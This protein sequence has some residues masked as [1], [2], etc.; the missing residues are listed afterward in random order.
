MTD[1]PNCGSNVLEIDRFCEECGHSL[2][3]DATPA[4][5]C[6]RCGA[7]AS[8]IDEE[9]FCSTCGFRHVETEPPLVLT[10]SPQLGGVSDPGLRHPR[11]EDYLALETLASGAGTNAHILVVC[12]GVSSSQ[13]PEQASRI[14]AESA[15]QTLLQEIQQHQTAE[16]AMKRAITSAL[17]AVCTLPFIPTASADPPSTTIVAAVMQA[18]QVTIGWLGDSRG[19]WISASGSCQLTTDHSWLAQ[20]VAAGKMN[21]TEALLSPQAH[22]ITRWLGID[23]K[24]DGEPAIAHFT[25]PGLGYLLLCSDGL[26]NYAPEPHQ[27]AELVKPS[28]CRDATAIAYH[29]VEFARSQGGHDNITVAILAV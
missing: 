24:E 12:D 17:T 21:E 10:R 3:I 18:N 14:A 22:S 9:G 25:T 20:M 2:V 15:S 23:A 27:I 5:G 28:E 16:V 13:E 8:A 1:C 7:E 4:K 19:Y 26:W 6:Q 29:L 11:N